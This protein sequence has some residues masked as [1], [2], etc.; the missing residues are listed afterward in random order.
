MD[1]N[2]IF[3]CSFTLLAKDFVSYSSRRPLTIGLTTRDFAQIL[4][5]AEDEDRVILTTTERVNVLS[6]TYQSPGTPSCIFFTL[7]FSLGRSFD[8]AVD[9]FNASYSEEG[10]D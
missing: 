5:F 9:I 10:S 6:V 8:G 1:K 2:S 7:L 4:K 3:L